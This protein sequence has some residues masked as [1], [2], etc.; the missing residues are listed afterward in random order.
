MLRIL[1]LVPYPTDRVPGQRYRIEQWASH[2]ERAGV[3]LDFVPF[4]DVAALRV[5]HA[6]GRALSKAL[7]VLAGLARRLRLLRRLE[8][9]DAAYV[10]REATL[11]GSSFVERRVAHRLPLVFDFDDAIYLPAVSPANA[12]FGWLKRPGKTA[13]LCAL[14]RH[15]IAGNETLADYARPLCR[16]VSVVPSTIDTDSYVPQPRPRGARPIV[17]WTGSSTTLPYL[18]ALRPALQHL[19]ER[20]DFELRVIGA[21]PHMEGLDVRAVPWRAASEVEDLRPLDV[22]LMPLSDDAWGR[23]KCGMKALQYMALGIPPVVSPV[24]VNATLVHDGINGF[25]ARND[26][27]WVERIERVLTDSALAT[28]LGAEARRTVEAGYS[29]RLQA[30]RVAAILSEAAA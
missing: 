12:A 4:L 8:R 15:V 25:H 1:A 9:Y 2:L 27:E 18:E 16:R 11:L 26:A 6:P 7:G 14:A 20:R 24:G 30:P 10:Y 23:G 29:A 3:H 21:V 13:E 19:R 17:G 28:R 5:L 22:G